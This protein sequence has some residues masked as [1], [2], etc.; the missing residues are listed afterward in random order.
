MKNSVEKLF[1]YVNIYLDNGER[2]DL[3]MYEWEFEIFI[4]QLNE[5]QFGL[6]LDQQI[7]LNVN[8]IVKVVFDWK[9]EDESTK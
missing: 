7:H 2:F 5:K 8:K 3:K 4:N 1:A 9:L 6:L